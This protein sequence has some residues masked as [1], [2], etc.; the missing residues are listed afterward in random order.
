MTTEENISF[1]LDFVDNVSA[2][3]Q[4]LETGQLKYSAAAEQA[5]KSIDSQNI[6]FVAQVQAVRSLSMGLR[7]GIT[8]MSTLGLISDET[9]QKLMK[10]HAAVALV[11]AGFQVLKGASQILKM[12]REAEIALAS[13]ETYRAVL[14]S[15]KALAL[16]AVAGVAAAGVGGYVIGRDSGG[17]G[18]GTVVTQNVTFAQGGSAEQRAM[19]QGTLEYLGGF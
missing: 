17:G 8:A 11:S 9:T 5:T 19:A 15:P 14:K 18:M 4:R 16:I 10:M 2:T 12:L 3:T 1:I 13:V 7:T 6:S